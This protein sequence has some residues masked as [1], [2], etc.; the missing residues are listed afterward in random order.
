MRYD[1][2]LVYDLETTGFSPSKHEIIEIAALTWSPDL[3]EAAIFSTLI[4]P[5]NGVPKHITEIT[6]ISSNTF[7]TEKTTNLKEALEQFEERANRP[8]TLLVSHNGI[9]FDNAFLAANGVKLPPK[10]CYDTILQ[11]RADI[12]RKR[13]K[14]WLETQ[15]KAK[16]YRVKL[17]TNLKSAKIY[18][19][20]KDLSDLHRATNDAN[21]TLKVFKKQIVKNKYRIF[22]K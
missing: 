13:L 17:K 9:A 1:E 7:K 22:T 4:R 18:Y 3:V 14:N 5:K 20:I 6:G 12:A 16:T 10:R 2:V 15:N 21:L 11:M 8:K 19:K